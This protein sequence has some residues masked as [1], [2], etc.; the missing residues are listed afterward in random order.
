[1]A[2]RERPEVFAQMIPSDESELEALLSEPTP[3][4][5]EA[6]RACEGDVLVLGAG[7][8][9]GPSLTRM[10]RR[11]A[12]QAG[13]PRRVIAVS[14][15]SSQ[16]AAR[17]L[18]QHGVEVLR[19]DLGDPAA[20]RALPEG[21]NVIYMAGQKFGTSE[22]PSRT[23]FANTAVPAW[24]ADRYRSSRI[25]AFS[26]GNVYGLTPT[27]TSGSRES[28]RLA[29]VGEY[30]ASCVGRERVFEY[31]ADT[32][33]TRVAIIRLNYAV[34]L[35]Y[36]VLVDIASRV[37]RGLPVNVEMG[38][39]NC[40]WQG[41]ANAMAVASLP[42]AAT[43]AEV[44]NVTGIDR[45]SVRAVATEFARR[46]GTPA[47]FEGAEAGDALLSDTGRMQSLFGPPRVSTGELVDTVAGWIERGGALLGKPT[48][49]EERGGAF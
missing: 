12:D 15:F 7:G 39:F 23:W 9:M 4:V 47:I 48:H 38:W 24:V 34:D 19:A 16:A 44:I 26:T 27:A 10:V 37:H 33:G 29:P 40:I 36:G 21:P 13:R 46:F 3:A 25:V 18:G 31:A 30:A 14:R 22:S 5:I 11:G 8:K 17:R 35:R 1:M 42:L 43:P 6:L 2:I 41:D 45:L 20:I 49:F 28:D 32:W